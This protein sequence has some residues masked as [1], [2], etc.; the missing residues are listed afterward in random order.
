MLVSAALL[1]PQERKPAL[2]FGQVE[3][4]IRDLPDERLAE[5]IRARSIDPPI[6]AAAL[7]RLRAAG[8]GTNTQSALMKFLVRSPLTVAVNPMIPDA[9]VTVED[10]TTVTDA[11]GRAVISGLTPGAHMLVVEKPPVH[12]RIEQ[13][14]YLAEGGSQVR[15]SLRTATGRMTVIADNPNARVEIRNKGSYSLPLRDLELPAGT[16]SVVI[17]ATNYSP[18]SA[19]VEVL[20]DTTK[21]FQPSLSVDRDAMSRFIEANADNM[22]SDLR[23]A[24]ER[25]DTGAFRT[26]AK[27][28]LDF[29]GDKLFEYRLLHHHASG[30]HEAKLTIK[31]SGLLYEPLGPCQWKAELLPW[32]RVAKTD[33]VRQGASGV[34]LLVDVAAGKNFDKHVPLNFS[35]FGSSIGQETETKP[36]RAGR[37]ILGESKTTR[38]RVRS[39]SSAANTLSGLAW[40]I[41]E[42]KT[43][44]R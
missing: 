1:Y 35:V 43:T 32:D 28:L 42:V 21:V 3:A 40:L 19:E 25:G 26:K 5:E 14:I 2:S 24:L 38:N 20:P 41:S 22:M 31:R 7:R 18:Y 8:A 36:L 33:I 4:L 37:V 16:Y 11:S 27:V 29:S 23:G 15:V 39:P 13:Q 34:L 6:T 44:T 17:T 30:F 10:Q 12:P 9:R